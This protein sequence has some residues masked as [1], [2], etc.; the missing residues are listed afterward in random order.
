MKTAFGALGWKPAEFWDS[1]L[2]EFFQAIEGW[3]EANGVEKKAGP[4]TEDDLESLA[5]RYGG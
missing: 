1:T 2:T 3:N 4:P 5:K